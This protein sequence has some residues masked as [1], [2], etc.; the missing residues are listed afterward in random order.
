MDEL[1][2]SWAE[3]TAI[4]TD[5]DTALYL[6]SGDVPVLGTPRVVALVEEA[7]CAAI[8][9]GLEEGR[10]TVGTRIELDHLS[11]S[12]VGSEITARAE[13]ISVDGNWVDL[14]VSVM[15][16]DEEVARGRHLRV[17]VS[18]DRFENT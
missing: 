9:D 7:S 18:R 5:T 2:G 10:T 6:G 8:R 12:A 11:P 3:I 14:A 1:V 17:V 4:V 15:M 16:G 13:V